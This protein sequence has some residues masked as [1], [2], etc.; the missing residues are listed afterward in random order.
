MARTKR[1]LGS[2]AQGSGMARLFHPSTKIREKGPGHDKKLRML[3]VG[4]DK[5]W[6]QRKEQL[7]YSVRI[8]EIDDQ[9]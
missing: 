8:P 3:V 1:I 4:E 5:H 6:V 2:V 7:C 9:D